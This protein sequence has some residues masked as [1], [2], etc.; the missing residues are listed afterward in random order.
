MSAGGN[1]G[2]TRPRVGTGPSC[3]GGFGSRLAETTQGPD[4]SSP[5]A[6]P[7]RDFGQR[8]QTPDQI[9][10]VSDKGALLRQYRLV[11]RGTGVGRSRGR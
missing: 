5:P 1:S 9:Q 8:N 6:R 11:G 3:A 2:N 10:E 7:V 4:W